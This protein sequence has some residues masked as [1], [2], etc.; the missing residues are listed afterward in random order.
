MAGHLGVAKTLTALRKDYWWPGMRSFI[1][2]YV[3]GCPKCQESKIKTH[4][5]VPPIQIIVPRVDA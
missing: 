2:A 4:P 5:N 3:K 1:Q